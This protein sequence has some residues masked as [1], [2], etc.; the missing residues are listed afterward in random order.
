M[1]IVG[2]HLVMIIPVVII[3]K[4]VAIVVAVAVIIVIFI[5][6][7]EVCPTRRIEIIATVGVTVHRT[8][9]Y[10]I[11]IMDIEEVQALLVRRKMRVSWLPCWNVDDELTAAIEVE[12]IMGQRGKDFHYD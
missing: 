4:V 6:V 1:I 3:C 5:I 7:E 9:N 11:I 8:N 10:I 12:R 2:V